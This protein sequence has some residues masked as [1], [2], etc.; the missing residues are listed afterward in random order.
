M[1]GAAVTEAGGVAVRG[2]NMNVTPSSETLV[3]RGRD[4]DDLWHIEQERH[5]ETQDESNDP[6]SRARLTSCQAKT[7][8]DTF[9]T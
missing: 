9:V 7:S 5:Q 8:L 6:R 2:V 3:S 4:I 1:R